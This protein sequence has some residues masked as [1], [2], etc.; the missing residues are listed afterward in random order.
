MAYV[1]LKEF[2]FIDLNGGLPSL[3]RKVSL[4][5]KKETIASVLI[6]HIDFAIFG[7][8]NTYLVILSFYLIFFESYDKFSSDF[9]IY[10]KFRNFRLIFLKFLIL[11]KDFQNISIF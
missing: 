2:F 8:S 3:G 6:T 5:A 4:Q 7:H 1:E 10:C 9:E 11:W